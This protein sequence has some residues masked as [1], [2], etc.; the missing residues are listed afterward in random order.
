MFDAEG[1]NRLEAY[2]QGHHE[3]LPGFWTDDELAARRD[4]QL[5]RYYEPEDE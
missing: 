1:V 4:E 3:Q 5:A 2:A